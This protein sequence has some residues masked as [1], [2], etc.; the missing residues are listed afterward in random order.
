M[1]RCFL[2]V[3][4]DL[5]LTI[6][7]LKDRTQQTHNPQAPNVIRDN[8][9]RRT[10]A[11]SETYPY[12]YCKTQSSEDKMAE[13][14][15]A[16]GSNIVAQEKSS[17]VESSS[18]EVTKEIGNTKIQQKSSDYQS[19]EVSKLVQESNRAL[20]TSSTRIVSS[21]S[22]TVSSSVTSQ[23]LSSSSVGIEGS[24]QDNTL[25][26]NG[27]QVPEAASAP[28]PSETG[29]QQQVYGSE[30]SHEYFVKE[31]DGKVVQEHSE[32]SKQEIISGN[33]EPLATQQPV[34][35]AVPP[36]EPEEAAV[37]G[38]RAT[39]IHQENIK[40]TLK[41]I[42]SEIEE[43]VVSE[44]ISDSSGVISNFTQRPRARRRST[45]APKLT[46]SRHPLQPWRRASTRLSSYLNSPHTC[47][48]QER[49]YCRWHQTTCSICGKVSRLLRS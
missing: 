42:I 7:G 14:V 24:S 4:W 15:P 34:Q 43:A 12:I 48:S 32:S 26:A 19:Q 23:R 10:S 35:E 21:S 46:T 28:E 49:D 20:T 2:S 3:L 6:F 8:N 33:M 25:D 40:S 47:P 1:I 41:E 18:S 9:N 45:L 44:V 16:G 31:E 13:L 36:T 11:E 22:S 29:P 5:L 39:E 27:N 38:T 37:N 30:S 17:S